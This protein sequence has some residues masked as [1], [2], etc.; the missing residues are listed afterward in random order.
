MLQFNFADTIKAQA[1]QLA[2]NGLWLVGGRLGGGEGRGGE[3]AAPCRTI[4]GLHL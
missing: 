1:Q 4:V 2:A 3:R